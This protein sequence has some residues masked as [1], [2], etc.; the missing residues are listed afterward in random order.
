MTSA[1]IQAVPPEFYLQMGLQDVLTGQRL[2]GISAMLLHMK[3][4][5]RE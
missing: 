5:V 4:L 2:S 3:K 1:Q